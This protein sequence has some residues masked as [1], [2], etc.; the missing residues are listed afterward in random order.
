LLQPVPSRLALSLALLSVIGSASAGPPLSTEDP[1]IL[2]RGQWEI[3]SAVTATSVDSGNSYQSPL[4]DIS[5]G[6]IADQVQI[7]AAYP[8]VYTDPDDDSSES[9]FGNLELGIKWRFWNSDKLQVAF[10][11]V[12]AFGVS[13]RTALAGIGD[14]GDVVVLPLA[15]EYQINHQWR[16]TGS[17]G[18]ASVDE[19]EDEWGYGAALAYGL[20]DR[21][22]L[23]F[24]L[25]GATDTDFDEDVLNVRAGFD[26]ALTDSVHF[27][28]SAATGLREPSGEEDLN[29]DF[30]FGVQFFH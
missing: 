5:L 13:R 28:F 29:Y 15:A 14:S 4:L 30:Y 11:P 27:L 1:G 18:Y 19:G 26:F 16:L 3:I 2:E 23:L 7:A 9:D 24:E 17:A 6:V 25:A 8:Y 22:E 20:N 12:Y 21:W 10:A